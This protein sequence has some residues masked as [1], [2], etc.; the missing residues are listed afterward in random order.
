M[1]VSYIEYKEAAQKREPSK[2]SEGTNKLLKNMS[3]MA[4][5]SSSDMFMYTRKASSCKKC[6]FLVHHHNFSINFIGQKIQ[7][8]MIGVERCTFSFSVTLR[9][10]FHSKITMNCSNVKISLAGERDLRGMS[11]VIPRMN[12]TTSEMEDKSVHTR[13]TTKL[14]YSIHYLPQ[15]NKENAS[16]LNGHLVIHVSVRRFFFCFH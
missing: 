12:G 15:T 4:I 7:I 14:V 3:I 5:V 1:I 13:S 16:I 2:H 9:F 11:I 10:L 6:I 8:C